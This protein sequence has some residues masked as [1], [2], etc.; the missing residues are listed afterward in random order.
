MSYI[1]FRFSCKV[2]QKA[3][4]FIR[5]LAPFHNPTT[6][7]RIRIFILTFSLFAY[8]KCSNSHLQ[9]KLFKYQKFGVMLVIHSL[10][11]CGIVITFLPG[12]S[13]ITQ[14]RL[15]NRILSHFASKVCVC[16]CVCVFV[17]VCVCVCVGGCMGGWV[18]GVQFL[19][20]AESIG[21]HQNLM[22]ALSP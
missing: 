9:V 3:C 20:V 8:G 21:A 17:C 15:S 19:T 22:G 12:F 4:I 6:N 5:H 2:D 13:C 16:V 18:R 1:C 7:Y 10:S 11:D 14:I